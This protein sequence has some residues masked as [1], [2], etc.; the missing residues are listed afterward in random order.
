MAP[1]ASTRAPFYDHRNRPALK[2]LA[3]QVRAKFPS[4]RKGYAVD[5]EGIVEDFGLELVFRTMRGIAVEAYVPR[6]ANLIVINQDYLPHR[7][8]Y[9]FTVAEELA[10]QILEFK[11]L[12]RPNG[13]PYVSGTKRPHELTATEHRH[14]EKCKVLSSG[15]SS[16]GRS[17][18]GTFRTS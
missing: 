11:L 8:R 1:G 16:A 2:R 7:A 4:R 6:A 14:I 3:D 13:Q 12:E 15:D 17:L 10:H 5:I 18:S 9:R